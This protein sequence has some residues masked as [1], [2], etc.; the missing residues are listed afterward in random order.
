MTNMAPKR[1]KDQPPVRQIARS[2]PNQFAPA[3]RRRGQSETQKIQRHQRFDIGNDRERRKRNN[4]S[5]RI[6]Q[7]VLEHDRRFRNAHRDRGA[8]I[9]LRFL[10][11]EFT[12]NVVGDSNPVED[13]K[14]DDQQPER[15]LRQNRL[16][17]AL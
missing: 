17:P 3:R 13:G 2:L 4:R 8:D 12:A 11:I 10:P 9:V 15:R 16:R 1:K 5:Q 14:N 6:R 7:D